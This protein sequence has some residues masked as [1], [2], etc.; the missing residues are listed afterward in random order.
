MKLGYSVWMSGSRVTAGSGSGHTMLMAAPDIPGTALG[1][2]NGAAFILHPPVSTATTPMVTSHGWTI[3]V[4]FLVGL[5]HMHILEMTSLK[6]G[7]S[8]GRVVSSDH[9][10]PF[11][12]NVSTT[13]SHTHLPPFDVL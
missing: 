8:T 4:P 5:V 7:P 6:S 9:S 2:I 10:S 12:A 3:C 13:C 11:S 1:E